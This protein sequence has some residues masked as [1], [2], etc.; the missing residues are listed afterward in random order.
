MHEH[1]P[2]A[3][4]FGAHRMAALA[5]RCAGAMAASTALR[6]RAPARCLA[7]RRG[8]KKGFLD[9]MKAIKEQDS[10]SASSVQFT[11]PLA[12]L[13]YPHP[14]LRAHNEEVTAFDDKLFKLSRAMF[15]IMYRTEVCRRPLLV[16][17]AWV[18][19]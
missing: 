18:R 10:P 14:A 7:A 8:R 3:T 17:A 9:D 5:M 11:T 13:P 15:D 19:A 16:F 12:I 2:A 1:V 4:P 6:R